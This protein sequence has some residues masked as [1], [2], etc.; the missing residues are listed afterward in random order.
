MIRSMM[1]KITLT[2]APADRRLV[3]KEINAGLDIKKRL[4]VMGLHVNDELIK[5]TWA[6][7]GPVLVQNTSNSGAKVALGRNLAEMII[8]EY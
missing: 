8:V 1:A 4:N 2:S 6:K 5:H 3:I 7:W